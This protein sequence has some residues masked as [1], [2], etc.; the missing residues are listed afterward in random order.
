MRVLVQS[1][2]RLSGSGIGV[3]VSYGVACKCGS[4]PV[5]LWLWHRLRAIA[6]IRSLAWEYPYA[7]GAALKRKTKTKIKKKQT[8][9]LSLWS[10]THLL[11]C[12]SLQALP[13]PPCL[14]LN[15]NSHTLARLPET[16][17]PSLWLPGELLFILKT[18]SEAGKLT[19]VVSPCVRCERKHY[20]NEVLQSPSKLGVIT[21]ASY[22][23]VYK[24]KMWSLVQK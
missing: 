7:L 15:G 9:G 3:A 10:P 20:P 23:F 12:I 17:F 4:D 16:A 6:L 1:L 19:S 21:S 11:N 13:P 8:E 18:R 2:A 5:L 14:S 24:L 22:K